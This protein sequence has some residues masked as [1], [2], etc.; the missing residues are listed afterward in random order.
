M[1]IKTLK[2]KLIELN[3]MIGPILQESGYLETADLLSVKRNTSNPDENFLYD[4][5]F[6]LLSH[7]GYIY[8]VLTYI[9]KP[10]THEGIMQLSQGEKYELDGLEIAEEDVIEILE[11]DYYTKGN[12]WVTTTAKRNHDLLGKTARIRK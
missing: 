1:T 4:E 11:A 5:F 10:V 2:K 8:S 12:R 7:L 3:Q 6:G 9:E